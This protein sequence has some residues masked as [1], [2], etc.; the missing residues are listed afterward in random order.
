MST[1]PPS[2]RS[3]AAGALAAAVFLIL[4]STCT[5]LFDALRATAIQTQHPRWMHGFAPI[6]GWICVGV[7]AVLTVSPQCEKSYDRG[8]C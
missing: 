1:I 4:L 2:H 7:I 5:Q 6:G 8:R 3:S